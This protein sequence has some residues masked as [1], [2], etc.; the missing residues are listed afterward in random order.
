MRK[1]LAVL[2]LVLGAEGPLAAQTADDFPPLTRDFAAAA[3][4]KAI[5]CPVDVLVLS[6][7]ADDPDEKPASRTVVFRL[8]ESGTGDL[9]VGFDWE[10]QFSEGMEGDW[11]DP[12]GTWRAASAA[13][14]VRPLD[15]EET[16][17]VRRAVEEMRTIATAVE[18]FGVDYELYPPAGTGLWKRLVPTYIRRFPV[19]DPWGNA[20]RYETGP[21][22]DHYVLS[23]S[24]GEEFSRLPESYFREVAATGLGP[25]LPGRP[26]GPSE[27]VYSDG[28]F[29]LAP[30]PEADGL[31]FLPGFHPCASAVGGAPEAAG[32][33]VE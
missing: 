5:G 6:V 32:P 12:P 11:S 16:R 21:K 18:A 26:A 10:W 8:P 15:S 24:G 30:L 3:I 27:I 23:S 28:V 4:Q 22:R 29:L 20:Y 2:A 19:K 13:T 14:P 33:D 7:E 9:A 17:K 1:A 25:S 31:A